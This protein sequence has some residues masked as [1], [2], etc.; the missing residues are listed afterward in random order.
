M[1]PMFSLLFLCVSCASAT[2]TKIY[3]VTGDKNQECKDVTTFQA[4]APG[5]ALAV[6]RQNG[7]GSCWTGGGYNDRDFSIQPLQIYSSRAY[8]ITGP[9]TKAKNFRASRNG[10]YLSFEK[11]GSYKLYTLNKYGDLQ[12]AATVT[13]S[14]AKTFVKTPLFADETKTLVVALASKAIV[15]TT[16]KPESWPQKGKVYETT[17][18]KN[19]E[20]KAVAEFQ[21]DAPRIA[22]AVL[23][24]NGNGK[25][26]SGGGY[27]DRDFT[28][29]PLQIHSFRAYQITGPKTKA[30]NFRASRNGIY[31][32]FEK[33]GSYKLYT[34]NKHG[35]LQEAATVTA[36]KAKTF[37]KTSLFADETKTLVVT[38]AS[39]AIV[40]TTAKPASWPEK[41]KIY[42]VTGDKNQECKAVA[43]FK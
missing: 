39:K 30:K 21:E 31:L 28:I 12:E 3:E 17:G 7:K 25:C 16:A 29:Q 1:W 13:A 9:K 20:C 2:T 18:D 42:E 38:L 11:A 33:A 26:W 41:G 19:Q 15:T 4:D 14:K 10:I 24:Q 5:I 8:K 43:E 32:S 34:L 22:L 35:D 27:N 23:R 6:L 37:V 40:T 36:S